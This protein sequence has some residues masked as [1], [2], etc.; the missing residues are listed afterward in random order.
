M[1]RWFAALMFAVFAWAAPAAPSH[2]AAA[3]Q[4]QPALAAWVAEAAAD[5]AGAPCQPAPGGDTSPDG[6]STPPADTEA[7]DHPTD[8]AEL[9]DRRIPGLPAPAL[10]HALP[11]PAA[12]AL[13][14]P[15]LQGPQRPPRTAPHPA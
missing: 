6:G 12:I 15:H 9:F 11:V 7:G 4:Q 14:T 1:T 13:D 10:R 3:V 5:D 2:A 8:G